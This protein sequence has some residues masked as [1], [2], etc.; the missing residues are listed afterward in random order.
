M[1]EPKTIQ[2]VVTP[3]MMMNTFVGM[4]T[5]STKKGKFLNITYSLICL[6]M[7]CIVMK[8]SIKYLG[9]YY[10]H[11][12][13]SL[14]DYTF[15][16]IFYANICLTICLIPCGW[17]RRKYMKAAMMR[18]VMCEKSLE[19][20]GLDKNYRKLYRNQ[21]YTL[22][23]VIVVFIVFTVA[24]YKEMFMENTP[25]LMKVVIM[26]AYNYPVGLLYV[27]D[28]SFLHWVRYSK[29]RFTQLNNLLKR[30]LTT[31]PDSPQH[32]RVLK[33]KDDWDK[34]IA[35]SL[36]ESKDKDNI[37]TMR[38]V[39]QVH[40]ELIK[41]SRSANDAFGMQIL[42]SMTVSF[43]FITSLLYYAYKIF[44]NELGPNENWESRKR[45]VIPVLSWI[46]FYSSKILIVN[47]LC[48]MTSIRDFTL[49]LIQNPLTF[50]ACGFFNLD[51]TFIHG[52]IGSVTTY[53]V[54][55]I[56]VGDLPTGNPNKPPNTTIRFIESNF[57]MTDAFTTVTSP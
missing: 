29:T 37:N 15:Q 11:K 31:T 26:F 6:V 35:S 53:L 39:K 3:T 52:V 33:M 32:K 40:L 41:S 48:A 10:V 30:M 42:F 55:L 45:E 28:I 16:G 8:M 20:I 5:W 17:F 38:A 4:G 50:T 19:Q 23:L 36:D 24:N 46:L 56:Q 13:K 51:H 44:W 7:Y 12:T 2:E 18:I 57:T 47:H 43:V 9:S 1:F 21:I 54:I 34:A 27:N 49:Q 14:G 25:M 22:V